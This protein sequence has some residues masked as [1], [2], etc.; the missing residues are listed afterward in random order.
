[1]F[2]GRSRALTMLAGLLAVLVTTP[3]LVSQEASFRGYTQD[4]VAA[5]RDWEERFRAVPDPEDA[6]PRGPLR[7]GRAVRKGRYAKQ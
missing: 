1:M 7:M 2:A 4:E 3:V 6:T 5:Q